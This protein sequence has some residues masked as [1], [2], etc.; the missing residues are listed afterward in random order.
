MGL[1]LSNCLCKE[2]PSPLYSISACMPLC[3]YVQINTQSIHNL[4]L[5][6]Y[7]AQCVRSL[8]KA[9]CT[10]TEHTTL[11]SIVIIDRENC[12]DTWQI[13]N[14]NVKMAGKCKFGAFKFKFN[15]VTWFRPLCVR[16]PGSTGLMTSEIRTRG[17]LFINLRQS[18]F[19]ADQ[20]EYRTCIQ[21][22]GK[23]QHRPSLQQSLLARFDA[24]RQFC[25]TFLLLIIHLNRDPFLK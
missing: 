11:F 17:V 2:L 20:D 7:R 1:A 6:Y 21:L 13:L 9:I 25:N 5:H 24:F 22:R 10:R 4:L 19:P 23:K 18:L 15:K 12:A 3:S 14:E 16:S 8:D